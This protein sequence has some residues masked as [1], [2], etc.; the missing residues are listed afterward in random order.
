VKRDFSSSPIGIRVARQT[1]VKD[2]D[3]MVD[4]F[5]VG[6]KA[7]HHS[8]SLDVLSSAYF[9]PNPVADIIVA[10]W[11]GSVV[12]MGQWMRIYDMFWGMFGGQTDWLYVRPRARGLGISAAI[13]AN[14]CDRIRRAGGEFLRGAGDE[15]MRAFYGRS[16]KAGGNVFEFHIS[17][18][19]L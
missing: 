5:V 2:L 18:E 16:A 13:I 1:D 14:I 15:T 17:A 12:A 3:S 8:R 10:E 4:E 11:K 19:G 7:E 9:G 6:H